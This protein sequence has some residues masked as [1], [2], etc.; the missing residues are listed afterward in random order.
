MPFWKKKKEE[1]ELL[2][3]VVFGEE[4]ICSVSNS[5]RSCLFPCPEPSC[6]CCPIPPKPV[7]QPDFYAQYGVTANPNSGSRLPYLPI[8]NQGNQIQLEEPTVILLPQGYL[9]LINYIF[10]ATPE[11][12]SYMQIVPELNGTIRSLY[13]FFAPSS[14]ARNASASGSFTTNE[15]ANGPLRLSIQLTYSQLVRNIDISGA[16]SITP[17]QII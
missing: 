12:D 4:K 13:S 17:I 14:Q 5:C 7:K 8:F 10:L 3:K 9:Y 6:Q 1:K 15:A 2:D 11:A 16:V